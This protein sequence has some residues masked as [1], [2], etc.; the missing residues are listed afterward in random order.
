M[1][2]VTYYLASTAVRFKK[3]ETFSEATQFCLKQP[4]ESI[5]EVKYYADV[6]NKKP[7]RN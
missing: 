3:F 5:I 7:D 1:Y 6:D 2:R 4:P